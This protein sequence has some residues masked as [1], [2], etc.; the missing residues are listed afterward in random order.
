M[1]REQLSTCETMIMKVIWEQEKEITIQQLVSLFQERY[2]RDYKRAT[3]VTFLN[4]LIGKGFVST[5]HEGRLAYIHAEKSQDEYKA[6]L[7]KRCVD[8]WYDGRPLEL[9]TALLEGD[10]LT[11]EEIAKIRSILDDLDC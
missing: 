7:T 1:E 8:Y 2:Q 5:R 10:E 4:R 6:Y 3:I 9:V 11:K